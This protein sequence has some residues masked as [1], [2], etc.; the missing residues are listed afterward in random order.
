M[1][2]NGRSLGS[3]NFT[4]SRNSEADGKEVYIDNDSW[5]YTETDEN[6]VTYTDTGK[7]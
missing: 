6:G 5:S 3:A 4:I 7:D 1:I 2:R